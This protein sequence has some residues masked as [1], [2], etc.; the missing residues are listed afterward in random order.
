MVNSC[1]SNKQID[2]GIFD[3]LITKMK[4]INLDLIMLINVQ[5]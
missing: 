4:K 5:N 3:I 2:G 1:S